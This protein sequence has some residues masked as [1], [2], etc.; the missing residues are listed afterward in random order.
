MIKTIDTSQVLK[1]AMQDKGVRSARAKC[2]RCG[3]E[4]LQGRLA[5]KKDS[6][7]MWCE[8]KGCD[9]PKTKE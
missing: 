9:M 6:M 3:N 4:T 7:R 2:P 8:T 1:K 5:G